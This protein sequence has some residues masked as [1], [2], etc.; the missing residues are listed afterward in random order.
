[1]AEALKTFFNPAVVRR[2]AEQL[3]AV[4]PAFPSARFVREASQGLEALELTERAQHIA[5]ALQ[6]ALP[7]AYPEAVDILV[8]SLGPEQPQGDGLGVGMAPFHYLPHVLFVARYG[9]EH[10][11]PSL[12]A[13]HELT[14]RFTAE[15]SIRFFIERYPEATLARLREWT[16]D[17]NSHVRRLV[18]EGT[19]PRLPWAMRLRRFQEDPRPVLELLELLKDD[20]SPYVRRSVANN[21]ND[22]GKDHPGLLVEV[23]ARWMRGASE[24]RAALV[25]HALRTAVKRGDRQALAVLGFVE[26]ARLR[27]EATVKPT[28]VRRG[29]SIEVVVA[30]HNTTRQL[31]RAVVDLAVHFVKADG[32][33]RPKV[34]KLRAVELPPGGSQS[35]RKS[36]SFKEMTTRRHYPGRHLLE[37]LVNGVANPAGHVELM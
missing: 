12:R 28:R 9:L 11:E 19:R 10:L 36:I 34:F 14:R 18:S 22:I 20:S 13:Q 37:V 3:H 7:P 2:I 26:E 1:M 4:H 29:E 8:R 35:L 30:V 6:R 15:F 16:G 23:C 27:V 21:L 24:E 25:R 5:E 32:Q 31:Q 17:P 33:A